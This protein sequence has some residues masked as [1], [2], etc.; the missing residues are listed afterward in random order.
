MKESN[1]YKKIKNR[2]KSISF[3]RLE[4]RALLGTPDLLCQNVKGTFFTLELKICR[5]TKGSVSLSPHQVSFHMKHKKNTFV[6]VASSLDPELVRLFPGSRILELVNLGINGAGP[7][8]GE[9]LDACES[10]LV[11]L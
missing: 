4:N 2:W 10:V 8:L 9:G 7:P 11:G 5:V 3:I 6:L 1:F